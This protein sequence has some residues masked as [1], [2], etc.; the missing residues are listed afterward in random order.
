MILAGDIGGTKSYL[1]CIARQAEGRASTGMEDI[2]D[3]GPTQL[4]QRVPLIIGSRENVETAQ[5]FYQ[6]EVVGKE[7]SRGN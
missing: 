5:R 7:K 3:I 6:D 4:Y 2:L 1:A